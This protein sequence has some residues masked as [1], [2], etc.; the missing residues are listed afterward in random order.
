MEPVM[1]EGYLTPEDSP[2][3]RVSADEARDKFAE[4]VSPVAAGEERV[5]GFIRLSTDEVRDGLV[6][7]MRR[8]LVEGERILLQQAG[9]E[10]A[11]IIP[12]E[13]F[14]RLGYLM[15]GLKPSQYLPEEEAYY[16]HERGIHCLY[17]DDLQK[18]FAYILEEVRSEG[19]LLGCCP[20]RI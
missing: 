4:T 7:I 18:Y 8:V 19:E 14:N 12:V 13:E 15:Q 20:R 1:A 10:V 11:A 16:E 5:R 17:A 9:E 2:I 6:D 3:V